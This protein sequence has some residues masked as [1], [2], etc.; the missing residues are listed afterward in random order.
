MRIHFNDL[1]E[2]LNKI[3]DFKKEIKSIS[4][5]IETIS[6]NISQIKEDVISLIIIFIIGDDF[7]W[8]LMN[9]I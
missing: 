7:I 9:V 5:D 4:K 1:N 8:V 6:K 3:N 2:A